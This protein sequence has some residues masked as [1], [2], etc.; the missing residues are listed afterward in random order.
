MRV[1][2]TAF[3]L[4]G[5]AGVLGQPQTLTLK[6]KLRDF[7]EYNPANPASHPDFEND[8]YLD[9]GGLDLGY[10]SANLATDGPVDTALFRDDNRGPVLVALN[11]PATGNACYTGFAEFQDWYN[12]N[13][14]KNRSFYTE[15]VLRNEGNGVYSFAD[16]TFFPL[17]PG[18]GWRKFRP[19]DPD[20]F[21]P[22]PGLGLGDVFGFTMELHSVFTYNAGDGQ[23]FS[24][25]GDD[26][27]WVFIN[28]RLVIDLGGLHPRLS[29]EVNLDA[30]AAEL[31]LEDGRH[32]RLDFFF[33]ERHST[34]SRCRIST[35]LQLVQTLPTPVATPAGQAFRD[36]LRV[37]LEVPGLPDAVI[38]YTLDGSDPDE[39][40][41]VATGGVLLTAPGTL[42]ARGY[43]PDFHPSDI[44]TEVYT[45]QPIALPTPAAT[46]PGQAF[47]DSLVVALAVPG[48]PGAEI[49]YTLDGGEPGMGSP[50]YTVPLTLRDSEILK[51]KAFQAD[52]LPSPTL[53]ESYVRNPA[54]NVITLDLKQP[55]SGAVGAVLLAALPDAADPIAVVG[56]T[57]EAPI[58]MACPPGGEPIA[59][60]PTGLPEWTVTSREPFLYEFSLFDNLGGFV[61]AQTGEVTEGMLATGP[62]ADAEGSRLVRFRW[63]PVARNGRLIGTGAY[64]LK[65]RVYSK[66]DPASGRP[67]TESSFFKTLG[68]VRQD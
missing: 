52:W 17:N 62:V 47:N 38:R 15:L 24:F 13:P 5:A 32:Y 57:P 33:A 37:A 2:V 42:K 55:I 66:A 34:A 44:L 67:A 30:R 26:D 23:V 4:F 54:P 68:Y 58:C 6:A 8:A 61:L 53:T 7:Q 35:S 14:A 9:C 12:D 25:S 31:G 39:G 43:H 51:A 19:G 1:L 64:V 50:L 49:R 27:V 45:L 46:P 63:I 16:E 22:V 11:H 40:S 41:P 59:L 36:S 21:G 65:A 3:L 20:P 56:G 60:S 29:A 28:D 48:H 10:V 18:A